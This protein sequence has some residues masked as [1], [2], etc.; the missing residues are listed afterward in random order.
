MR[1][2]TLWRLYVVHIHMLPILFVCSIIYFQVG[3]SA[4]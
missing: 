2:G 3:A 1:G 4:Y